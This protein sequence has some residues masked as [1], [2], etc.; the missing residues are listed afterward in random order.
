MILKLSILKDLTIAMH[1][2]LVENTME[3]SLSKI[4]KGIMM[5]F[6]GQELLLKGNGVIYNGFAVINDAHEKLNKLC[7]D[8]SLQNHPKV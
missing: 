7:P 5:Y 6:E 3:K 4:I 1:I 2:S 8:K